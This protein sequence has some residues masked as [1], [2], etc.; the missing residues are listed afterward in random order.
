MK[1]YVVNGSSVVKWS[2]QVQWSDEASR[3]LEAEATLIAAE[4]FSPRS[5]MRFGPRIAV[6]TSV[7]RILPTLSMH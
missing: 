3:L 1:V 6:V 7:L 2:E 4:L 5:A